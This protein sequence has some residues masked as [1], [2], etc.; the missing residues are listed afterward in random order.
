MITCRD[1][2]FLTFRRVAMIKCRDQPF[3][4]FRR[5]AMFFPTTRKKNSRTW[6]FSNLY[7]KFYQNILKT[8]YRV[9]LFIF[10]IFRVNYLL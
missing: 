2:P 1:R 5:G 3:I 7:F 9:R 4:T 6:K 10:C 8:M